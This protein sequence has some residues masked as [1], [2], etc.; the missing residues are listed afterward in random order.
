M[1]GISMK[2][3]VRN[4]LLFLVALVA[5]IALSGDGLAQAKVARVGI[6]SFSAIERDPNLQAVMPVFQRALASRGWIEGKNVTFVYRDAGRDPARFA[7]AAVEMT[8]A[9]VDLI[10]ATSAP[11]LRAPPTRS[12]RATLKVM[13][14][15][16]GTLPVFF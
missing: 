2:F 11:A 12:P 10:F 6:L 4:V 8:R 1:S 16:E 9:N 13:G 15:P 3:G 5:F 7:A 14:V